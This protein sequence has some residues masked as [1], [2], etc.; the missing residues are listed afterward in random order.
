MQH[1]IIHLLVRFD[2][3]IILHLIRFSY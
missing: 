1:L 3:K 2:S